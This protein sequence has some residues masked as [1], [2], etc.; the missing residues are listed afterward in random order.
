MDEKGKELCPRLI[1]FLV[2]VGR[3]SAS[4]LQKNSTGTNASSINLANKHRSG[5]EGVANPEILRRYPTDN[6]KDFKLPTD[7]TF[8][9]QPEGC[10]TIGSQR[11]LKDYRD[12]TSFVFNLTDKDS[13][14]IRHGVTLNFFLNYERRAPTNPPPGIH[15]NPDKRKIQYSSLTSLCLISHHPFLS[16]Y[17]EILTLLRQLIDACNLRCNQDDSLPKDAVWTVLM[18]HWT[19]PIPVPVMQEI[20]QIETWILTLL[21][22]PVP[23]PGKTKVALEILP[24]DIMPTLEFALPD[25]TR[26]SLVDFPLHLPIELLGVDVVVKLLAAT[27]LEHKVILQSRNYNAVSMCVMAL[28]ALLYPLEYMFPVIPLLPDFMPSSEQLLLAP[29]PYIIGLP[30]SFFMCKKITVPSDVVLVDLDTNEMTLPEGIEIPDF[31]E[32]ECSN[33][34]EDFRRALGKMM[35]TTSDIASTRHSGS[36][37]TSYAIDGDEIDVA[38]RVAMIKFFNSPNIFADF[39]EHTRTLRLYPRPVVAL[40]AESFLRSRPVQSEF[41]SELCKTQSVEYFAECSL[42]P[43]NETYV[44]VQTG[45]TSASQIGD[46]AKWFTNTLMPVHFNA[47]P[48]D[49][50]LADALYILKTDQVEEN[51]DYEEDE[52]SDLESC[53]GIEDFNID[54]PRPGSAAKHN[55]EASKPLSEVD[56]IYRAPDRLELPLSA[57]ALS[58]DSPLSSGLSSPASSVSASALD[59][60]ADFAR[61]AEN[62]A[63]KSDEKGAFTFDKTIEDMEGTPLQ[64]RR[65][66]VAGGKMF[67]PPDDS[68]TSTPTTR[69]PPLKRV[70]KKG[71]HTIADSSEKVFGPQ[72]MNAINGYAEKSHGVLSS[73][74]SKTAP[75]AQALRDK[76][77]RPLAEK[78]EHGQHFVTKKAN[79]AAN[80]DSTATATQQSKNQQTIRDICDQILAGQSIGVFTY[81]KVKRLLED[82]SLRELVCSKLNLG[83]EVQYSEDDFVQE[84]HISRAQYKGYLK[85]LQACIAGLEHCFN[86]PGSPGLASIFHVMEIAHTHYWGDEI[87]TPSSSVGSQIVTPSASTQ[88]LLQSGP[89]SKPLP[90]SSID[91][92]KI[93]LPA[94]TNQNGEMPNSSESIQAAE[95]RT[96]I[97]S[98]E[99]VLPLEHIAQV[100]PPPPPRPTAGPPPAVPPPPLPSGPPPSEAPPNPPPGGAPPPLPPRRP[101]PPRTESVIEN[102]K[103]VTTKEQSV[104]EEDG[105]QTPHVQDTTKHPLLGNGQIPS[106]PPKKEEPT[107]KPEPLIG[108]GKIPTENG[109]QPPKSLP[110]DPSKP[111]IEPVRHYLYQD[112]IASISNPFWQKMVFWENAFF[113]MVAQ[114]RDKIGMD[115]EPSEMIERYCGLAESEKKRLEL[116]EDRILATLLHN[117][118][119]YLV[120]CGAPMKMLQQKVRRLLGKA[121]IGLIYSKKIN[122]LLDDLPNIANK[123]PLKPLGSRLMQRQSFT[124]HTGSDSEG[125]M[126]F[127]EITDDAV[128]LRAINGAITERWWYEK[129]VNM[130]YS[131]KTRVL[132][133]WRR[134]DDQVH[135]HKFYTRKCRQLYNCMKG[136][137]ERAAARG[138][139]NIAGRDLGGEFPVHDTESNEGGLLQVRIDGI[140]LL[141]ANRQEFIDLANIKKCNTYG[142]NMFVLEEFN[143][144]KN[145]LIQ[146][147]YISP[148]ADQI[149][150]AVLCVFSFVAAHRP[151]ENNATDGNV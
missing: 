148:M 2:I 52:V 132:C 31:P 140:G 136:A 4:K 88:N 61:F 56:G 21:S 117:L 18:G 48:K 121:H 74:F 92:R 15:L 66:T 20:R 42:C 126:L 112:L 94:Y 45:I 32:P 77:M 25:H 9:C 91:M 13:A 128:I 124:V 81:P 30:A 40:Q 102:S 98:T 99:T 150:Y 100:A 85:I 57:S 144:S 47:Y 35:S 23:V 76:T 33:L 10:I 141:F 113:D 38:A 75:K 62:L 130:T 137:M 51:S 151:Q 104:S 115:Q 41:I 84:I 133:L 142:G 53:S 39:S 78:M 145:Q 29:T 129:V 46:K 19:D 80:K 82:E 134:Q 71:L 1:D 28:V 27:M 95:R 139:V 97:A 135:M 69:T 67:S 89:S 70:G 44:R 58:I 110:I 79:N 149:C 24:M 147:K 43:K 68:A 26:F 119:A 83:L 11:K 37:E 131:P 111:P 86:T 123:I 6:H 63:L 138:K 55:H 16:T 146:R 64:S 106:N 5:R 108:N 90:S 116:D 12:T 125:T 14:K 105:G 17:R 22:S 93:S 101:P 3:R 50:T 49:S 54:S 8:F 103:L 109:A 122:Q 72:L 34:K 36:F 120:M 114:E 7:V 65:A 107:T 143:V 59:S 87:V 96:S 118:T 73:V 60:E 127:M